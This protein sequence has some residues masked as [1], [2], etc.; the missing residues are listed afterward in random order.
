MIG[1]A[2]IRR[3]SDGTYVNDLHPTVRELIVTLG[4]QLAGVLDE[5]S[6][7]LRRL[8]P[9][10]YPDDAD[11]EA[12]Y[13]ILARGELVD[14]RRE[15][16]AVVRRTLAERILSDEELGA[17][18][19][20]TNDLRLVLGTQLDVTEDDELNRHERNLAEPEDEAREIYDVLGAVAWA[21][22]DAL[23]SGLPG[24]PTIEGGT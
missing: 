11:R 23:A 14:Q 21:M 10:A 2:P 3:R 24:D 5:D 6:P 15:A 22:V 12:G 9:T 19:A 16:V 20:V 4:E 18:L 7:V 17:W 13:R 8:F 1:R